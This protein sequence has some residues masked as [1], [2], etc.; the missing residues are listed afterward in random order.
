MAI[1]MVDVTVHIDEDISHNDRESL[2]ERMLKK[3]GVLAA[4]YHDT[5]PHLM[6]VEYNPDVVSSK[7]IL[8]TVEGIGVHAELIGM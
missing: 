2:R 8:K 3:K 5:Q 7:E 4:S 6:V 1:K